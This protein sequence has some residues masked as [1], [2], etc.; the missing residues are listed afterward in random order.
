MHARF[1][2]GQSAGGAPVAMRIFPFRLKHG[3]IPREAKFPVAPLA[4]LARFSMAVSEVAMK[5]LPS[6]QRRFL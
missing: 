1:Y 6:N 3:G 4:G 2:D 5:R